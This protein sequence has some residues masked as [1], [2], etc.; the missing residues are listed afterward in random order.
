[1]KIS[2]AFGALIIALQLAG[3]VVFALSFHA[4]YN[5]LSSTV[6]S[7][8]FAVE[9]VIDHS[10]G[11]GALTVNVGPRNQGFLGVELSMELT[12]VDAGGEYLERNSTSGRIDPGGHRS[13]ALSLVIPAEVIQVFQG[14]EAFIEVL[15]EFRTLGGLTGVSNLLR[16]GGG[17]FG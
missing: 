3:L 5:V 17:G 15:F 2:K 11:V 1:L 13:L 7:D 4:L 8:E 9:L 14:E 10:S 6:S 12:V 16:L